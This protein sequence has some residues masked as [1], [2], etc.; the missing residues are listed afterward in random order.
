MREFTVIIDYA[1]YYSDYK[2]LIT[3]IKSLNGVRDVNITE[4]TII[5]VN[6]KYEEKLINDKI[7]FLELEAFLNLQKYPVLYG[8]DRH[9]KEKLVYKKQKANICC[10]FCFGNIIYTLFEKNGVE[11]VESDY[12]DICYNKGKTDDEYT[13]N[14]YYN[15]KI[16][17]E[18]EY[19]ELIKEIECYF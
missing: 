18:T 4:D 15:P 19:Q 14:I 9:S 5:T 7:I 16:I 12:Y 8:F 2:E 6:V 13:I 11:K 1:N 10:E 3:Y 17:S